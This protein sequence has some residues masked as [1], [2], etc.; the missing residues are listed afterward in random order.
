MKCGVSEYAQNSLVEKMTN[1]EVLRRIDLAK[2]CLWSLIF[3][4]RYVGIVD[5]LR[6]EGLL[7]TVLEG[8]VT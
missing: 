2:L 5:V 8:A 6:N 4:K 3:N 7:K 1:E